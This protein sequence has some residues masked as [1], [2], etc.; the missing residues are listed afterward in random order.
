MA[1]LKHEDVPIIRGL[2]ASTGMKNAVNMVT[3]RI[4]I[5]P[6]SNTS[7]AWSHTCTVEKQSLYSPV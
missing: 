1:W 2:P 6:T 4:S 5:A 3:M 7:V